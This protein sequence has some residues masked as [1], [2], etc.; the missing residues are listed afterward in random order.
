MKYLEKS[1]NKYILGSQFA[2]PLFL[3]S[4]KL[5]MMMITTVKTFHF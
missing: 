3:L 4:L 1:L 2:D 5:L